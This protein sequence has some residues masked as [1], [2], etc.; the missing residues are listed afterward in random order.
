VRAAIF[1]LLLGLTA[2]SGPVNSPYASGNA[3]KSVIYSAFDE[4]PKHL[5]PARSYS[6][7]E[8]VYLGNIY[9]PPLQYHYLKRPYQLEPLTATAMPSVRYFDAQGRELP[10]DV[11]PVRIAYSEYEIRLKTGTRYQ[12]HPCFARDAGDKPRY[13]PIDAKE[14][15]GIDRFEDFAESPAAASWLPTITSTRYGVWPI[16]GC[17]RPSWA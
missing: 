8:Y 17:S 9:E 15:A 4:R 12:P 13:I 7:N 16:R 5:D 11:A 3:G 6:E 14:L 1:F 10:A 2:C